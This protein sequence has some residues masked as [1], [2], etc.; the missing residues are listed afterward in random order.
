MRKTAKRSA[1]VLA[2]AVAALIAGEIAHAGAPVL[3]SVGHVQRHP[4]ATWTL[5]QYV[6]AWSVQV[7]KSPQQASDGKFFEENVVVYDPVDESDTSWTYER[8]LAPGTYY[9]AVRGFDNAC[10]FDAGDCG[11]VTSNVLELVIPPPPA[12]YQAA[13]RSIHRGAIVV[14]GSPRIWTYLGD[15]LRVAFRNAAALD[16]QRTSYRVCLKQS[17]RPQICRLRTLRGSQTDA[18]TIRVLGR[19]VRCRSGRPIRVTWTVAGRAVATRSVW[20]YECV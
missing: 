13:V 8:Q 9:V 1:G 18:W 12:R 20:F 10:L 6:E 3:V 11:T 16:G 4:T 7:A 2:V 5:P 14:R 15:T 19:W 17:G